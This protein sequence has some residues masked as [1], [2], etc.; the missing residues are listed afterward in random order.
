[1]TNQNEDPQQPHYTCPRCG[2]YV[3]TEGAFCVACEQS[4]DCSIRTLQETRETESRKK[5]KST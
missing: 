1:M 5:R 3:E 2:A 4:V